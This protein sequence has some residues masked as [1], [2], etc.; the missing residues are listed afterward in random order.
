[1]I[2][3]KVGEYAAALDLLEADQ[4]PTYGLSPR[5]LVQGRLLS[6]YDGS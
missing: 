4:Y 6:L 1:M 5:T 3:V 2:L